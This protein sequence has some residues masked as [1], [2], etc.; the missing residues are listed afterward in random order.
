MSDKQEKI[1][2]KGVSQAHPMSAIL[3][4]QE[5]E[6][7]IREGY[8]LHPDPKGPEIPCFVGFPRCIMVTEEYAA[9]LRNPVVE[10]VAVAE[11]TSEGVV[12]ETTVEVTLTPEIEEELEAA[13][14]KAELF[15]VAEKMDVTVPEDKK[16]PKAIKQYLIN[17][18]K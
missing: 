9:S 10:K 7:L 6:K 8:T 14:T 4:L 17:L 1:Y 18:T 3:F 12:A 5:Y 2:V 13:K 15:A 11:D 16:V